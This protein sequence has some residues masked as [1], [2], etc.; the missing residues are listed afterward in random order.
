MIEQISDEEMRTQFTYFKKMFLS[1]DPQ[2]T[3]N[4]TGAMLHLISKYLRQKISDIETTPI[5]LLLEELSNIAEGGSRTFIGSYNQKSGRRKLT[6]DHM[7]KASITAGIEILIKGD[8]T[9]EEALQNAQKKTR[10][11]VTRLKEI[12][13]EVKAGK[14]NKKAQEW[15]WQQ[16]HAASDHDYENA[17]NA[18]F[19]VASTKGA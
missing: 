4:C 12:R 18:L 7:R 2:V 16:V 1:N 8:K 17:A 15:M 14:R 9:L 3:M 11:P 6:S 5:L 13:R 19:E 10:L